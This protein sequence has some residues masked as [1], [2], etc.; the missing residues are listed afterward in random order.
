MHPKVFILFTLFILAPALCHGHKLSVFAWVEEGTIKGE[1]YFHGGKKAR[2]VKISI[3]AAGQQP[4]LAST[5]TDDSGNFSLAVPEQVRLK[6]TDLLIIA[7]GGDGHR[8]EWLIKS[9][10]L[11]AKM[12]VQPGNESLQRTEKEL[13]G[14]EQPSS[15]NRVVAE[16]R[17]DEVSVRDILAGLCIIMGL[18]G[19]TH[20]VNKRRRKS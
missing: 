13:P 16:K 4:P 3:Q 12:E 7:D 1:A 10:E 18:A 6:P 17:A 20:Y 14:N 11:M 2:H 8:N 15:T 5:K 9:S 19:L